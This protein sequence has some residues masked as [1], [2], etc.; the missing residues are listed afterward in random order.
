MKVY[1]LQINYKS[2][3]SMVAEFKKF[4]VKGGT[5]EWELLDAHAVGP[6]LFE[7]GNIESVWQLS[8][9]EVEEVQP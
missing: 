7:V 9:R 8:V 4:S 3:I 2:G 6:I 1:T 5:W